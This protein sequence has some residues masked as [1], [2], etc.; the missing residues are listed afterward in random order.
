MED[1]GWRFSI[2]DSL[3]SIFNL[4]SSTRSPID[5]HS[6]EISVISKMVAFISGEQ[7]GFDESCLTLAKYR[8][9]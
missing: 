9:S 2:L 8:S 5:L 6:P 4:Q 7:L 3:S 1:G